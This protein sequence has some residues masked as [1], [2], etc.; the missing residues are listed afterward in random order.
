MTLS[1]IAEHLE[2]GDSVKLLGFGTFSVKRRAARV[3]VNPRTGQR[4]EIK[5][6][7]VPHFA[8]GS[9]LK[10]V[11]SG[12]KGDKTDDPGEFVREGKK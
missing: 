2:S 10:A 5:S 1:I 6:A 9:Q 11:T 3:G 12:R 7:K 4:V 8:P